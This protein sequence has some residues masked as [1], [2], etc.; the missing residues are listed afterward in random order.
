MD[1]EKPYGYE[2]SLRIEHPSMHPAFLTAALAMEP[3][4]A[5]AV[6]EPKRDRHGAVAPGLR[7]QSYW[8]HS[9]GEGDDNLASFL[10]EIVSRLEPQATFFRELRATGG[11][12]ELLVGYFID[13]PNTHVALDP[14]LM[15]RYAAL[16]A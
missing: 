15:A 3:K 6:G 2:V 5:W 14:E 9:F 11:R 7:E 10:Q 8:L 4:V 1:D 16:G 12:L 13:A